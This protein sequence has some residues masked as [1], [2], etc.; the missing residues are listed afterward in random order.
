M[1]LFGRSK[2]HEKIE[3]DKEIK[4]K[5]LEETPQNELEQIKNEMQDAFVA[6]NATSYQLENVKDEYD[7]EL[8]K[9]AESKKELESNK[10]EIS[11]LRSEHQSILEEIQSARTD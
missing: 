1:G 7:I 11:K 2:K 3:S 10:T 9:L 8:K 5:T 6:L 4:I